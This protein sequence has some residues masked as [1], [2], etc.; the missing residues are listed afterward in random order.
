MGTLLCAGPLLHQTALG[1]WVAHH[2]AFDNGGV[3][4]FYGPEDAPAPGV[5]TAPASAFAP[6]LLATAPVVT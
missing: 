2:F 5:F 4:R 6:P 3:L 1:S